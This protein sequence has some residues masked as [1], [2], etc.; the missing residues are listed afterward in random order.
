MDNAFASTRTSRCR[1]AK[2]LYCCRIMIRNSKTTTLSKQS[3]DSIRYNHVEHASMVVI[4]SRLRNIDNRPSDHGLIA[5]GSTAPGLTIP[6]SSMA[7]GFR[8]TFVER[9]TQ[10]A[11]ISSS[12]ISTHNHGQD[13]K[14][15]RSVENYKTKLIRRTCLDHHSLHIPHPS[16]SSPQALFVHP[17]AFLPS[18]L[19]ERFGPL[20]SR[21][22]NFD[23]LDGDVVYPALAFSL[24]FNTGD[25]PALDPFATEQIERPL[26]VFPRPS[27]GRLDF[28]EELR[29][30]RP[31]ACYTQ[32]R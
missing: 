10:E 22:S 17:R 29:S 25:H 31:S 28:F 30:F 18:T 4:F 2:A 24:D 1:S 14:Y 13:S 15:R 16:P 5:A 23:I 20:F 9:C 3:A 12:I 26:F 19:R 27:I 21:T 11:E 6:G 32:W 8:R 7:K